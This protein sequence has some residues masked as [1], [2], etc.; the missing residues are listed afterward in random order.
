MEPLRGTI[1]YIYED[2]LIKKSSFHYIIP[3]IIGLVFGQLS[4]VIGGI[5]ISSSLGEVPFSALSTVEPIN[6]IFSAI[7]C[8]GGVGCGIT[9]SKCSGS[10]D[11]NIAARIF[12]RTVIGLVVAC[13]LASVAM[14][15]FADP[16]LQFLQ[17]TPENLAYSREYLYVI[18]LGSIPTIL[19]FSFFYIL[20][21]DNDPGLVLVAN[22]VAAI[23]NVAGNFVF[24]ELLHLGVGASAFA[25][26][27]GNLCACL[28][29]LR[30]FKKKDALCR[31]VK[32]ERKEGDPGIFAALKPG[33]PMAVMYIMFTI[34][35]IVQNLVL[36]NQ[37][38]TSGL[39]N[40]AVVDNLVL[41]LTIF[42]AS[43]SEPVMPLA[44]SYFGEGNRCGILLVKRSMYHMGLRIL[45]PIVLVLVAFPQLF[46]ALFSVQDPVMLESLPFAI[47]IVCINALFT[48]TNDSMVNF[49]SATERERLANISYAIQIVVNVGA[50]LGLAR[51][52]G[53]D[54]PWYGAMIANL[55]SCAFLL[56]AG[57]LSKGFVKRYP[58][59][60]L[61]LTG[62]HADAKQVESW[63]DDTTKVLGQEKTATVWEKVI[64]PFLASNDNKA[65]QLCAYSV[66]R[67]DNGDTAA[68]L[69][70]GGHTDL[71]HLII[72]EEADG[73]EDEEELSHVYGQCVGSEFNT[74]R[75]MMINFEAE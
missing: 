19:F 6:L 26:V 21:D 45:V 12:T 36:S 32:P 65:D 2:K 69:R 56:F 61:V 10:G 54:A 33:T 38:G 44:S 60:A 51:V 41:F 1:N 75:R 40:S 17:A 7:G 39:G 13:A 23:V 67:R 24:L 11:K 35:M 72:G 68:I 55:C 14:F 18:L 59:N 63:R 49:L 50:T 47:R 48:F 22:I 73:E 57:H 30:H 52:V 62:G 29:F 15:A 37:I 25:M 5:C 64:E 42:T 74:L 3:A 43:T 4:P 28:I 53:M 8:L 27:F 16:L 31:F 66:I 20:T 34:Q 46:M 71:K 58:E 9:I 70:Y